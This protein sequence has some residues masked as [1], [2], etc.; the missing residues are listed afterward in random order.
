ML[1]ALKAQSTFYS[2]C[3]FANSLFKYNSLPTKSKSCSFNNTVDL[4][5]PNI[6]VIR[7]YNKQAAPVNLLFDRQHKLYQRNRAASNPELSKQ[8][9]YLKDEIAARIADR[10]LDIKRRFVTINEVGA[11]SG[12][13]ARA[14]DDDITDNLIMCDWSEA[15]LNRDPD[16]KYK[17]NVTKRVMDEES[18]DFNENSCEAIVSNLALQ[19]VN[20][21]PGVFTKIQQSLLPDGVFIASLYSSDTLFEL[22]A[23]LQLAEQERL[24][25]ISP[26]ISPFV[27]PSDMGNLLTRTGFSIPTVDVDTVVVNYPSMFHLMDDLSAMGEGNCVLKRP[28]IIKKDVLYAADAIYKELYA[29]PDGSI[30]ATFQVVYVI[31]WK[32]DPSQP[33]ALK[34]GQGKVSMKTVLQD[35]KK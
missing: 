23:S 12:G 17:I 34:P 27:E 26:H 10:I 33:Q 9:D 2:S 1:T 25:G 6:T 21:L 3:R 24:G 16:A 15:M 28:N 7:S 13:F 20:D 22:R 14:L 11:G 5:K 35:Q 32:P 19:W 30:P 31:G 18:I 8:V 29:N 4:S